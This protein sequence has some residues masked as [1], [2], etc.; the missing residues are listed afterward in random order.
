MIVSLLFSTGTE[1]QTAG[2]NKKTLSPWESHLTDI[3]RDF[4]IAQCYIALSI[5]KAQPLHTSF[6]KN[7]K[8]NIINQPL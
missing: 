5:G 6:S 4:F 3:T 2:K 7:N 1:A 8:Y